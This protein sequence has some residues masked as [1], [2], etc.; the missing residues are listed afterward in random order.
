[1][2]PHLTTPELDFSFAEEARVRSPKEFH[3]ML[4]KQRGKDGLR[5]PCF[6]RFRLALRGLTYR[7]SKR[8][9]RGRHRTYNRKGGTRP[10]AS[11]ASLIKQ[12]SGER[13]IRRDGIRVRYAGMAF[14]VIAARRRATGPHCRVRFS[15]EAC[16]CQRATLVSSP[17]AP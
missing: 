10:N 16:P 11:R 2:A 6:M 14:A 17:T 7:R 1:M 12:A 13:E 15:E 4:Q 3:G 9:A 5:A 8:E